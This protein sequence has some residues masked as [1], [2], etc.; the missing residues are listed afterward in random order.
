MLMRTV[1]A[2]FQTRHN[3]IATVTF[4]V[5]E[6]DDVAAHAKAAANDDYTFVAWET[7]GD[8]IIA[9]KAM[10]FQSTSESAFLK[11]R[12]QELQLRGKYYDELKRYMHRDELTFYDDPMGWLK[13]K[14][15]HT[16]PEAFA[17]SPAPWAKKKFIGRELDYRKTIFGG[18]VDRRRFRRAGQR[19]DCRGDGTR[20]GYRRHQQHQPG[21]NA[22][23]AQV[24]GNASPKEKGG[25]GR[26]VRHGRSQVCRV[27]LG[28]QRAS[29]QGF[30]PAC[31]PGDRKRHVHRAPG[32]QV[33]TVTEIRCTDGCGSKVVNPMAVGWTCLEITGRWRCPACARTLREINEACQARALPNRWQNEKSENRNEPKAD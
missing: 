2:Y 5:R 33:A 18:R 25:A 24:Q 22:V 7:Q 6:G 28:E 4:N 13:G 9:A 17:R 23:R 20:R 32:Q 30:A 3:N 16:E 14:V 29:Q 26:R 21:R 27:H 10:G 8:A 1:I 15:R 31:W 12:V 11:A 19:Q